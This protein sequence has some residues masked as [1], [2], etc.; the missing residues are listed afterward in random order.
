MSSI[1]S[2]QRLPE[3]PITGD[4]FAEFV[5]EHYDDVGPCELVAGK[6]LPVSRASWKHG[7][8][9]LGLGAELRA[10]EKRRQTCWVATDIGV[11]TKR[12]PDTVRGPDIAVV[13]R[14]KLPIVDFEK[15][16]VDFVPELLVE[17]LS[18]SDRWK[19]IQEKVV[20]YQ[21]LG[22]ECL[23]LIDPKHRN[24]TE[25]RGDRIARYREDDTLVGSGLLEGFSCSLRE[26]F[27]P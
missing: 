13:S 21:K 15:M 14:A 27:T 3:G 12:K 22:V 26:I 10:F 9:Q 18:S 17:V 6:V 23:W 4:Q 25:Y 7:Y 1:R 2:K 11:Y 19:S 16:W 8:V 24:L 20:E 5:M